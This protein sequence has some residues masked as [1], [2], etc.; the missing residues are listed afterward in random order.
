MNKINNEIKYRQNAN[1]VIYTPKPVAEVMIKMC[2][3][4]SDDKV[5]DCSKGGGVFYDNLPECDKSYCEITED[6][7]YF[8]ATGKYDLIIGNPPYSLWSKWLDKTT[9]LTDKFCYIFGVMNLT[10]ARLKRIY[11]KGYVIKK[12]HILQ[13]DYWFSMSFAV[14]FEKGE[15]NESVIDFT[16]KI[17]FC[18]ICGKRCMRGR[19]QTIKGVKKK[20]SM[21]ECSE[22]K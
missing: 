19:T 13:V 4:Q 18:D 8:E 9:E 7:D 14:L 16:G 10:R 17:F 22:L 1:D 5:L 6:I 12:F 11:D 3:I 2:N 21:N 15:P 20:W